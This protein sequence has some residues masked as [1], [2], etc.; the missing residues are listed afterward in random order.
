MLADFPL[1]G[2]GPGRRLSKAVMQALERATPLAPQV[3]AFLAE[4]RPDVVLVTPLLQFGSPQVEYY[5][6]RVP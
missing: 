5:A 2:R 1:T 4:Q 3:Q 6:A